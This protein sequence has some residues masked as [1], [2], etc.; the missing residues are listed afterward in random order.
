MTAGPGQAN[1]PLPMQFLWIH[2]ASRAALGGLTW[3][4]HVVDYPLMEGMQAGLLST[5]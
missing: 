1:S 4:V 3:T 2:V 5:P